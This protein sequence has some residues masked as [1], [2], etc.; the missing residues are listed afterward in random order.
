MA[1]TYQWQ[2]G[3]DYIDSFTRKVPLDTVG[4]QLCDA[5]SA[6]IWNAYPWKEAVQ[7]FAP[8]VLTDDVQD[9]S[10]PANFYKLISGQLLRISP[11]AESFDPLFI[12][13]RLPVRTDQNVDPRYIRTLGYQKGTGLLRL[14][15]RPQINAGEVWNLIGEYQ[16]NHSRVTDPNQYTWFGDALWHV[17]QEGLLYHGYKLS[18]RSISDVQNQYRIFRQKIT[19]AWL[20][21][22]Q[23]SSDTLVPEINL[24][25]GGP[26][27]G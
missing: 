6:E 27:R 11:S 21:E 18:D 12:S 2:Q 5:V 1:F 16:L 19:E 10:S 3:L 8:I 24:G 23:G 14:S 26:W 15:E 25:T 9:Y 22:N 4:I 17:A 13:N 20:E 7:S